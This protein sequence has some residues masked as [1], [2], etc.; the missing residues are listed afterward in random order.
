ME[1]YK[2]VGTRYKYEKIIFN[3][4]DSI[5][6]VELILK[7][8]YA[9]E[10]RFSVCYKLSL[11][12]SMM[13]IY[14]AVEEYII[15]VLSL[16]AD[17]LL[18]DNFIMYCEECVKLNL[19]SNDLLK[20]LETGIDVRNKIIKTCEK[21]SPSIILE[22]YYNLKPLILEHIKFCELRLKEKNNDNLKWKG[23][24]LSF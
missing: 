22:L 13:Q 2:R 5:N 10:E 17:C 12:G 9:L 1:G 6:S 21:I 4:K 24:N 16:N 15:Y 7:S 20:G 19:M 23:D 11:R 8:N 18:E 14:A 3:L